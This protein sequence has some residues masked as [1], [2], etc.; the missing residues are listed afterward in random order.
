[1]ERGLF[2]NHAQNF[3]FTNQPICFCYSKRAVTDVQN[4]GKICIL[5]VEIDGVKNLKKTDLNPR[6]VFIKPPSMEVLVSYFR[7]FL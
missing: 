3:N 6:F 7:L 5:D 2:E 4:S 1:M